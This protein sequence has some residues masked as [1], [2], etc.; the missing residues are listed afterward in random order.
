MND[1][2]DVTDEEIIN[3]YSN[4]TYE[5]IEKKWAVLEYGIRVVVVPTTDTDEHGESGDLD[6]DKCKCNP[7]VKKDNWNTNKM[8]IHNAWDG[9]EWEELA[10]GKTKAPLERNSLKPQTKLF[11]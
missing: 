6:S 5:Q 1:L 7:E 9:R 11:N 8:V 4:M 3:H 2:S 10:R